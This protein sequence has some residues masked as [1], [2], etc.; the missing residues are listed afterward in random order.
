PDG[1]GRWYSLSVSK[2]EDGVVALFRD[3]TEA[4]ASE[5]ALRAS[6]AQ[7]QAAQKLAHVGSWQWDV[8]GD[9]VAWSDELYRIFGF[10]P[11]EVEVDYARYAACL[12]PDDREAVDRTVREAVAKGEGYELNHRVVRPDG[13][14]RWVHSFGEVATDADGRVTALQGTAQDVTERVEAER[15]LQRYAAQLERAQASLR[16]GTEFHQGTL[17]ALTAQ[18]A[19]LDA[20]GNILAVNEAWRRFARQNDY[21]DGECGLGE[22]Y[23]TACDAPEGEGVAAEIAGGIRRLLD[24]EIEQFAAEYPCHSPTEQRWFVLRVTRFDGPEGVR[25]VTA[26]ENVSDMKRAQAELQRYARD[27]EESNEELAKFAYVASH[28]LQEP[29]RMVTSFLQLLERRYEGQLDDTAREY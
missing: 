6:E 26:H 7:L 5:A 8:G 21:A 2:L 19:I 11:G 23:L 13:S 1:S 15:A 25:L 14:V 28:D 20:E 4:K 10:E 17:D 27:L 3:I 22:N 24:G 18:V 9:R 29:L 12:H 16:A